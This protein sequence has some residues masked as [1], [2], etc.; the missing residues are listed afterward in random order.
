MITYR[1]FVQAWRKHVARKWWFGVTVL[2]FA[3]ANALQ[4]WIFFLLGSRLAAICSGFGAL[5]GFFAFV[6]YVACRNHP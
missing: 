1:Q 4:F 6:A 3:I 2:I 5:C